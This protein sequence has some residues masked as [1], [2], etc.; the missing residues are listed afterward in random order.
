MEYRIQK[1]QVI[2][3]YLVQEK[4][5]LKILVGILVSWPK[6]VPSKILIGKGKL[7]AEFVAVVKQFQASKVIFKSPKLI[8]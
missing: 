7:I 3:E 1:P 5:C 2:S 8:G 4:I 6:A